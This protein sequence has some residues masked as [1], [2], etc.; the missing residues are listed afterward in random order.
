MNIAAVVF[1]LDGTLLDTL[2]DIADAMNAALDRLGFPGHETSAYRYLTGEGVRAMVERSLPVKRADPATVE[3]CIREFRAEY[4]AR[5]G[6]K[7]RPYP[8][9]LELLAELTARRIKL[10]VLSNKLDE[11]TQQAVR[12]FLPGFDFSPVIGAKPGLPPKPDPAGAL[13]ISRRLGVPP[14]RVVYLGDTGVDMR[15]AVRAG[16]FA[17]GALWG[18]RDEKELRENGARAVIAAPQGLLGFID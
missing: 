16:M 8:G 3:R 13:L 17:V 12:D 11:F 2:A 5:W 10:S 18:F 6:T 7:T 1:D 14:A 9:I 15:T 4:S